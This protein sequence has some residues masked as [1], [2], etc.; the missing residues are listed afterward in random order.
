KAKSVPTDPDC[1]AKAAA[2]FEASFVKA[3]AACPGMAPAIEVLADSCVNTLD[4][5]APGV[6]RCPSKSMSAIGMSARRT[7]NCAAR[8]VVK[9]GSFA[10]CAA[11]S[12][13][14]LTIALGRAGG[15][16]T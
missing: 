3:G 15:C 10:V 8:D 9:P 16:A 5:D 1:L 14:T 7:M 12:I 11:N 13:A 4:A 6:G 2:K